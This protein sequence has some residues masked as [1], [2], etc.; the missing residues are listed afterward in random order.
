MK[1]SIKNLLKVGTSVTVLSFQNREGIYE[2]HKSQ[3]TPRLIAV[4]QTNAIMFDSG[5]WLYF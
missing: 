5:S 3:D 4:R 1:A 2:I